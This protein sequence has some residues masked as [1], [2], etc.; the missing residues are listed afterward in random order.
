MEGSTPTR[1]HVRTHVRLE[2][3][4]LAALPERH[5]TCAV[6]V[7]L[8]L[9]P[10]DLTPEVLGPI[11]G[12]EI[13]SVEVRRTA[14]T[15]AGAFA[16]VRIDGA[17][18]FVKWTRPESRSDAK[19]ERNRRECR[20]LTTADLPDD[21]PVPRCYAAVATDDGSSTIV[22]DDLSASWAP[23]TPQTPNWRER[24]VDAL[25]ALHTAFVDVDRRVAF[26]RAAPVVGEVRAR[27]RSRVDEMRATDAVG[28]EPLATLARLVEA[29]DWETPLARLAAGD[30]V[31]LLHG[32]SHAGNFLYEREGARAMLIDWELVE[33][34]VPTDD[35]AMFLGF[36][37]PRDLGPLLDRYRRASGAD[38]DEFASDWRRSVLRLPLVVTA[39]WQNGAR[40]QQLRDALDRA[41]A[42]V[43][44]LQ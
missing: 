13:R 9:S 42:R 17:D 2:Y 34:G 43:D 18:R 10:S 35:L 20:L 14:M 1:S 41:L 33:V 5:E 44:D 19:A 30:R 28:F 32:D 8:V 37:G 24:A 40:G 6:T 7:R 22:L 3:Y 31:T 11:L 15:L 25:A 26:E 12:A 39:F 4:M 21:V 27:L 29:D 36:Y 23:S 16:L 38:G